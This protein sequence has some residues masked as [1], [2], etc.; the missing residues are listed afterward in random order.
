LSSF[1]TKRK[2]AK[3]LKTK[4]MLLSCPNCASKFNLGNIQVQ[5][6]RCPVCYSTWQVEEFSF[7]EPP[8]AALNIKTQRSIEAPASK[9]NPLNLFKS[10]NYALCIFII[11][12]SALYT[13]LQWQ[14]YS[15]CQNQ[16]KIREVRAL[17]AE[18]KLQLRCQIHNIGDKKTSIYAMK[19][20]ISDV[21]YQNSSSIWINLTLE[22]YNSTYFSTTIALPQDLPSSFSAAIS[23]K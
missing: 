21:N 19:I 23:L 17:N 18:E 16:I 1:V 5:H 6:V 3:F 10:I 13:V 22:P 9:A 4:Q 12:A 11:F 15:Y 20:R 8:Y 14:R 2:F 7:T